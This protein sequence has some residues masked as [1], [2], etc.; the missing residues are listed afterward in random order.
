MEHNEII[1]V[2]GI[3]PKTS[4]NGKEY[5]AVETDKGQMS[6]FDKVTLKG[7][8]IG[9]KVEVIIGTS[10]ENSFK[11]IRKFIKEIPDDAEA[12]VDIG[13]VTPHSEP[14]QITQDLPIQKLPYITK[15]KHNGLMPKENTMVLSYV[16]DLVVAGKIKEY[17]MKQ[18]Y[19]AMMEIIQEVNT[20]GHRSD[21][22]N[23]GGGSE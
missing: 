22:P 20:S 12:V 9:K 13:A 4:R 18:W 11:N 5:W 16:K 19:D 14:I 23:V 2:R 8:G 3:T 6:V 21:T 10:E 7:L 17:E 15:D 1:D